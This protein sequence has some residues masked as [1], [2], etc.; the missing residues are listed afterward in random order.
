MDRQLRDALVEWAGDSDDLG[1]RAVRVVAVDLSRPGWTYRP[2]VAGRTGATAAGRFHAGDLTHVIVR[3]AA[4]FAT[5]LPHVVAQDRAFVAA[6][7]T[8]F[9]RAWLSDLPCPMANR[10]SAPDLGGPGCPDEGWTAAAC[11]AGVACVT[12]RRTVP[13][14]AA[15]WFPIPPMVVTNERSVAEA[16]WA[17]HGD[18]VYKSTSAVRSIAARLTPAHRARLDRLGTCPTQFQGYVPGVDYR[19]HVVGDD[20][21][22]VQV[23]SQAVDYH[24]AAREG[25]PRVMAAATLPDALAVRCVDLTQHLGLAVSGIDLRQTRTAPG[26]ASR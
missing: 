22:T 16:F 17:E 7:L 24:Y 23:R 9:L 8:A 2:D 1:G 6:E 13:A 11:Q 4:V 18:V 25:V 5:H 20:V 14:I 10:P 3:P 21:F 12:V 19:V 26:T 15:G